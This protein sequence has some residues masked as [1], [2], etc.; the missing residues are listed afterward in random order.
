MTTLDADLDP[1]WQDLDWAIGQMLIMGWDGTEV[2]PQIRNLIEQHHVGSILLTAKNLKSAQQTARL[3]Q[4]LQTIAHQAGHP[5]PLLI[6]LDQE[7][8]GVNSLYDE[9]YICQFPSSMGQAAASSAELAY[10]VAKAT[11]T[12]VSA[13]GVNLILGPV[14]D[15]LTNARYQPLGVRAIGDDP[16]EVSQYGIAS[17]NGYK[18]AGLATCGKHFPSYGNLDFLGSSLD[19]PIITQTLEELSL[20]ALVPF[21][22]AIATGNLDAMFIG[23]CGITNPSMSVNHACLSEQV[24]D[25]LLRNELGFQGVAISECLEMEGLRNE[26]GVRTGT[27][28]AVEAGCDLV[29]LC[30]AYDVQL[31]AI[32]GLKLGVENELITKERIYT[33]LKR[34]FRMKKSCTSWQKALNPPGI[35]L[36]SKIHPGH[37]ALSLKA[38][39]DSIAV[40][41]D[42]DKLLPLP[43]SMHQEEELLL[44]TP[45]VKPLPASSMTKALLEKNKL[46][47]PTN[48]D[49]WVHRDRGAIMSGEG[50]FR[51]LGRSLARARHGK[52]LHTSY[53]ANGVRPVHENLIN[54]ASCIIIV[55][56][57][58]N[59]N[60]YQAGFTKHVS[61]MCSMLRASG[62]KK[63]LIVVAVSSPYDFAMDKSVGAYICTFD[64]TEMAMS[65][66]VRVLCGKFKPQGT[67]PGTLRKS[68]KAL[69]SRQHWLVEAYNRNRD[70]RGLNDLLQ[71]LARASAP[72]LQFL[73]TTR[74]HAFELLNPNI[75]E[76]HFVVRNSS[77]QALYGFCATY[78]IQ[79]TG[80]MGALFVDPAKRNVSIGRSLQRRAL[81]GLAQKP[82]IKK[83]QLGM[84]FPGVFLGIPADDSAGLKQWFANGGW[85]LQFPRRLA[86]MTIPSLSN[87]SAPEGLLQNIQRAG[88]SFD[89]I[90]GP[91]NAD[92]VLGHIIAHA[93]PEV[94]ELYRFALQETKSCGV[95]RAK[96]HAESLLG[97][98]IICSPGSPLAGFIP[99]LHPSLGQEDEPI[100][101]IVAPLVASSAPQASLVLQG[102]ALMGLRQNKAHKSFRSVL[103]WVQDEAHEPLLA[104][105]FEAV[106]AFEEYTNSP[107]NWQ[108]LA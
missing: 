71:A 17:M 51:E 18:D 39:D 72:A 85:D 69:K 91:D 10:K 3:V 84:S 2:T 21:R 98:V 48:H 28:M 20:S 63:S 73:Q 103:S 50:V 26:I 75:E 27:V 77:T 8:G 82:G 100:G 64:F 108:D 101:G 54:R 97:T 89:L 34:V 15:V 107:D 78:F 70:A 86:N 67:L 4:E 7:N 16:Q 104:M 95:V 6:A 22:N 66:L 55:T 62:Q 5:H 81:R 83:M 43:N 57:D 29:L 76:A 38:Y 13:V 79:G 11:A 44:L 31:E 46:E 33:S 53:T 90:H 60:L 25:D 1:L 40:I 106:Q 12:E 19:I 9:D 105:G 58:A 61:M 92:S 23:G 68:R 47:A 96:G 41:R 52:L 37:L 14:L 36:L 99:P 87:W 88:I 65:A 45:L 93:N 24:I 32:A 102:L 35:S 94:M 42:N 49:K 56:A 80:I 74:A 59:R 30:R